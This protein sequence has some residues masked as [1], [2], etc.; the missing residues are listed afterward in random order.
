[1]EG[2]KGTYM[3]HQYSLDLISHEV[4]NTRIEQRSSDGFINATAM[5]R[6]AGKQFSDYE[7]TTQTNEFLNELS[8]SLRVPRSLLT[9]EQ[10]SG[11]VDHRGT[12]VHPD[13]A[14]N[15]GQWLSP[16]FAVIVA[17]W[18][19]EWMSG[20]RPEAANLPYHLKRY[21][22]NQNKVPITH[23]SILAEMTL[24]LIAPL[25]QK[26][27][28]LPDNMIPDISQGRM[29]AKWLRE[30]KGIE[31]S[32][33]PTYPHEYADGRVVDAKLYPVELLGDFRQHFHEVWMKTRCLEYFKD[34]DQAALPHLAQVLGERI[35][36]AKH[37]SPLPSAGR[38]QAVSRAY[39]PHPPKKK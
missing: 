22:A 37:L 4:D 20:S 29:F 38:K 5:C 33:L 32:S 1:M 14:I 35:E 17:Q 18:V 23:F 7:G 39:R 28:R 9:F 36:A 6:A 16:K 26:G 30:E 25:E 19:R 10:V 2:D 24:G 27:Y 34:R 13:V 21:L 15:L 8:N 31:T 11:P 3:S 12:W